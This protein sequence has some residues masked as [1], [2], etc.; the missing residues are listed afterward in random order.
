MS[1]TSN[2]K[3]SGIFQAAGPGTSPELQAAIGAGGD[4]GP[5]P[6]RRRWRLLLWVALVV[7]F[8]AVLVVVR[9]ILLPFI[10]AI[11]IA[12]ILSPLVSWISTRHIRGRTIP[13][14]IAVVL[15]YL[16]GFLIVYIFSVTV[17]PRFYYE[18]AKLGQEAPAFFQKASQEWVPSLNERLQQTLQSLTKPPAGLKPNG[19]TGPRPLVTGPDSLDEIL[20]EVKDAPDDEDTA[21][22]KGGAGSDIADDVAQN[23]AALA[24]KL[25][26]RL[27]N[28]TL[29]IEQYGE[30]RYAMNFKRRAA[31]VASD[32]D[33]AN[34][35]G[36]A[37]NAY[38]ES[39]LSNTERYLGDALLLGRKVVG[40]IIGS[41]MTLVLT[42]MVAAFLLFDT[43]RIMNFF[44]SL[45]PP[46]Y[47]E[48]YDDLLD[49]IDTGLGGVIRGQ[50]TICFVNGTL[51]GIGLLVLGV[52]YAAILALLA[53]IFSLIPIFGT[54]ISTIPAA[55]IALTQSLMLGV[56]TLVWIVII[57]LIEAN[58]LNPKIL[59]TSA[60]IHPA[61][62]VFALIA[63]EYTYGLFGALLA[64]PV[65]S[66]FQTLFLYFR[67]KAYPK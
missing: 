32:G 2:E 55:G 4:T 45:V 6:G 27:E 31:R 54:I 20:V 40:K 3:P 49:G 66:I 37:L 24:E 33:A 28:Y 22:D 36:G 26:D 56:L 15:I 29:D 16:A 60:R 52:K 43:P 1:D 34:G 7:F 46:R 50:L 59:G 12:Y 25:M 51:T 35:L 58:I 39:A 62:V 41:L 42:L 14:W 23:V 63:G 21:K 48:E 64:V 18:F 47:R 61:L 44:R 11:V 30:G 65:F 67:Q 9:A 10:L 38:L 17:I 53:G 8:V 5:H 13:R 57:H 19:E